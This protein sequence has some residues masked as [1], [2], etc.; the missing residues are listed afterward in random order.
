MPS[1]DV[2]G[3]PVLIPIAAAV[4]VLLALRSRRRGTVAV[5]RL[6]LLAVLCVYGVGLLRSVLF[7]YP[8]V[9]GAAR[10]DLPPWHVFVQPLPLVTVPEDPSGMVLNVLLFLPLGVLLPLLLRRPTIGRVL[11]TGA[12]VSVGIELVQLLGDVTISTGRIADVDDLIGNV[13]GTLV[14]YGLL[15]AAL[16]VPPVRALTADRLSR[17]RPE[18]TADVR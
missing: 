9:V 1:L 6:G 8:L 4:L 17:P 5:W 15:R 7:P 11:G 13:V 16:L 3:L 2:P 12:L 14:G 18:R 10:Q